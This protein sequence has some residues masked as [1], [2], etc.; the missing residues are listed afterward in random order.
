MEDLHV[1]DYN[2]LDLS[3]HEEEKDHSLFAMI[4][5]RLGDSL[6]VSAFKDTTDGTFEA[7]T[8]RLEKRGAK[9]Y[10]SKVDFRELYH[11]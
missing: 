1:L 4:D 7:G 5:R 8:T 2:D 6:P 9:R 10:G 11:V 3:G